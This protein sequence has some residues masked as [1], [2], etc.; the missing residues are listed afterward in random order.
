M[1]KL[2]MTKTG[3]RVS[4]ELRDEDIEEIVCQILDET[5]VRLRESITTLKRKRA[6]K[7]YEQEDLD[8]HTAMLAHCAAVY[9]YYGGNLKGRHRE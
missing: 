8:H 5:M 7:P 3:Y 6:R 1:N 2:Q 4:L 9:D